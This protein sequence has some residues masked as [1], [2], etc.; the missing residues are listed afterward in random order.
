MYSATKSIISC[1]LVEDNS[2][3]ALTNPFQKWEKLKVSY[4][5]PTSE[6]IQAEVTKIW[7][8]CNGYQRNVTKEDKND[9]A[10][11]Q[12][13]DC[14][15]NKDCYSEE[16]NFIWPVQCSP[17]T[18]V[19]AEHVKETLLRQRLIMMG[20][21]RMRKLFREIR[22]LFLNNTNLMRYGGQT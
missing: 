14:L 8:M 11:L 13:R 2:T 20:D 15:L 5:E 21:S 4:L 7:S 16:N 22:S 10:Q 18:S 9:G 19:S 1:P 6:A 17:P 12:C 3:I